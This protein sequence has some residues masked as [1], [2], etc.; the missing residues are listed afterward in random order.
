MKHV[1]FLFILI[2]VASCSS[3]QVTSDYDKTADFPKYKTYAYTEESLKLP[4]GQLNQDRMISAVDAELAAKGFT[5]SDNPDMLV[6]LLIKTQQRTE[7][8]AT[9]TGGY[10]G[11]YGRYGYGG[12][13]TTS[14]NYEQYTDGTLIITFV[15]NAAQKIFWQGRGTKTIDE[16][17]SAS[18]REDNINYAVKSIIAK[19]PPQIK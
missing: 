2:A 7:A 13:S 9:N 16:N 19:Y 18:K 10:Y 6:D 3:V 15:D 5:K 8:T 12:M 4:L 1:I 11:R 14:I 17:A